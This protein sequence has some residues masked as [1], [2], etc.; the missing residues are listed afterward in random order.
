MAVRYP[1]LN[2]AVP[3]NR[4]VASASLLALTAAFP[5]GAPAQGPEGE[6]AADGRQPHACE[7][8]PPD[9]HGRHGDAERQHHQG[10]RAV[11][12]WILSVYKGALVYNALIY[13]ALI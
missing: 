3:A 1:A 11:A 10:H 13:N 4:T 9:E 8:R 12:R 6:D 2:C 7:A 5:G